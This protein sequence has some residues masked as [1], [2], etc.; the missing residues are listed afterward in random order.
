MEQSNTLIS[1]F[2]T[3]QFGPNT[4]PRSMAA[5]SDLIV[6][7]MVSL[8]KFVSYSVICSSCIK[9]SNTWNSSFTTEPVSSSTWPRSMAARSAA[10]ASSSS[11]YSAARRAVSSLV[12]ARRRLRR[13]YKS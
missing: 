11:A 4:W 7:N 3:S 12:P 5:R 6:Q 8:L 2:S 9:Q 1:R 13:H 10:S